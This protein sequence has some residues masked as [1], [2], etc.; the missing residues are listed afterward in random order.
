[1]LNATTFTLNWTGVPGVVYQVQASSN[2]VAWQNVSLALTNLLGAQSWSE[3]VSQ[4]P[5]AARAA[6]LYRLNQISAPPVVNLLPSQILDLPNWKLTL[7]VDTSHAGS[8]DEINQPELSLFE[9]ANY[10]H[11]NADGDGVVFKAHCGGYTTSG[12]AYPRSEL[13]EM[14]A[15]GT[16][17]ASWSTTAGTHTME[18]RQAITHLPVVKPHVVAGQIH[19]AGDDV[20]VF[21]LEGSKLF[22]DQNGVDGPVLTANYRLGDVFTVKFVA[23]AGCVECHY[24][25]QYISKYIVSASGCYFKAGCYTQSNTSKGDAATA[26]G[27]VIIYDVSVKHE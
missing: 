25:G 11:A 22:I 21:R 17:N 8:P 9:D 26:Y 1:M 4:L 19:D 20:I 12:S 15:A 3:N 5:A 13:R 2:L 10:F 6:R 24:N 7:P 16:A 27:E 14:T 23:R 18:I